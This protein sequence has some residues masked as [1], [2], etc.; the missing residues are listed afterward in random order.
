MAIQ[1][2]IKKS[3]IYWN[4]LYFVLCGGLGL[5]G[6]YDYWV[7]IP[8][9]EQAVARY[10]ELMTEFANL[11]M[12]GQYSQLAA[13]RAQNALT[14]EERENLT[15]LETAMREAGATS[16]P[17]P[18]SDAEKARYT[19][20][21]ETLTVEFDNTPPELPA[22]YDRAVNLWLYVIGTGILG[23]PYFAWRLV[24]RRGQTWRLEDDGSFVTPEGTYPADAIEGIDMSIWMKKSI[25][26]VQIRDRAE[27][28]VLDDYEYQ[29]A[30]K[31]IG[32]LAHQFHPDEWT[33]DAKPVKETAAKAGTDAASDADAGEPDAAGDGDG[34]GEPQA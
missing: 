30:Y 2:S 32:V 12:R 18:L 33:E 10:E 1:T 17:P 29:D 3:F 4:L 25:A 19:E 21:K 15:K 5:W 20:I 8:A 27:P 6:A 34:D 9:Q 16:A 26:K 11:E 14:E 28:V 13:K 24:S 23:A 22:S 31:I 7:S